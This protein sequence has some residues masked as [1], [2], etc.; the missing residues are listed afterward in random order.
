VTSPGT[1]AAAFLSPVLPVPP[2]L[3]FLA[4]DGLRGLDGLWAESGGR[5]V[6]DT[7]L[8]PVASC[9]WLLSWGIFAYLHRLP[10][11]ADSQHFPIAALRVLSVRLRH[12]AT[13]RDTPGRDGVAESWQKAEPHLGW[14]RAGQGDSL[15]RVP[16]G[17]GR[18]LRC[19][20]LRCLAISTSDRSDVPSQ[21]AAS[22]LCGPCWASGACHIVCPPG[23]ASERYC[24][25]PG[26]RQSLSAASRQIDSG[27]SATGPPVCDGDP[28]DEHPAL[29]PAAG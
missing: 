28:D 15:D 19:P 11:G 21:T 2:W 8:E 23:P 7:G 26:W 9:V 17:S 12:L 6:G 3:R 13:L 4:W 25:L 14:L 5:L 1:A 22:H 24:L 29:A 20:L 27:C 16:Q 18:P 10:V